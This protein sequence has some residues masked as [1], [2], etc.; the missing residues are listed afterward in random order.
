MHNAFLILC[1][2][3]GHWA[4]GKMPQK[5][6]TCQHCSRKI[7]RIGHEFD[8]FDTMELAREEWRKREF[9]DTIVDL[10]TIQFENLYDVLEKDD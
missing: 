1:H 6:V 7:S 2:I 9:G 3:C 8:A 10:D 4:I 5:T